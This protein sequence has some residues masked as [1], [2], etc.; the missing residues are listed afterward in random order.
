MILNAVMREPKVISGILDTCKIPQTSGYT[1]LNSLIQDGLIA[2]E[3]T[4]TTP[5]GTILQKYR[6]V[7]EDIHIDIVKNNVIIR[8]L[9][10]QQS[11][12]NSC[13]MQIVCSR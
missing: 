4:L 13:L 10:P 12:E 8:I 7:F 5:D 11:F 9:V 6:T 2:S 3:G 1:K